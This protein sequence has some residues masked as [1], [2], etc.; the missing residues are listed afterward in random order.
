MKRSL[1][2]NTFFVYFCYF[3]KVYNKPQGYSCPSSNINPPYFACAAW[4]LRYEKFT[5]SDI[6][7]LEFVCNAFVLQYDPIIKQILLWNAT[8]IILV[9]RHS[10]NQERK[11]S[12]DG[13]ML[14]QTTLFCYRYFKNRLLNPFS[15]VCLVDFVSLIS[16]TIS[17]RDRVRIRLKWSGPDNTGNKAAKI[18]RITFLLSF[19]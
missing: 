12:T 17:F 1:S 15:T 5:Y 19:S 2:Q 7:A 4:K 18:S 3:W 10:W 11:P 13:L 14:R 16:D 6:L 8:L 9:L